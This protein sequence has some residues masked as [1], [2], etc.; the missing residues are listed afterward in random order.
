[1]AL[2]LQRDFISPVGS[3]ASLLGVM[4]PGSV[5]ACPAPGLLLLRMMAADRGADPIAV[6][7]APSLTRHLDGPLL[8]FYH[9]L[10]G[11]T[12]RW[13]VAARIVLKLRTG[14]REG[15]QSSF[16]EVAQ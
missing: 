1:M 15:V 2:N 10:V 13:Q 8:Y 3:M 5:G 6:S 14:G 11:G 4:R 16:Q 7:P 9:Y 12:P